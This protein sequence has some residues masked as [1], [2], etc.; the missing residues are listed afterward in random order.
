MGCCCRL[1]VHK[2][3]PDTGVV[4]CART[5]LDVNGGGGGGAT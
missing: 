4:I 3:N 2:T 5:I 1:Q